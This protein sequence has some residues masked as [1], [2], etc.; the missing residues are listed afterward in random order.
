M[1]TKDKVLTCLQGQRGEYISGEAIAAQLGVGRNSVWKSIKALQDEGYPIQAASKRGYCLPHASDVLSQE[2]L[3]AH[4]GNGRIQVEFHKSVGSTNLRAKELAAQ[5]AP[6]G[7]LVVANQQTA[8]RGRRG[9]SFY[10]PPDTGVYF[11]FVLRPSFALEDVTLITSYA[12]VCT[13]RAI[14]EV[15]GLS[16]QIKW[17]NDIFVDRRKCCGILTEA[18]IMPETGSIDYVVLG[19][20]IN[21]YEPK[22]GFSE[23]S[24]QIAR[25]L[26]QKSEPLPDARARVVALTAEHFM[27]GYERIPLKEHLAQYRDRSLLDGKRVLI[28]QGNQSFHATVLGIDDDFKLRVRLDDGS[29]RA[30]EHGEA[31][32]PSSQLA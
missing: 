1:S 26:W 31:S 18:S 29:E 11:S 6:E 8:G 15:F 10:S 3:Q 21:V 4:I 13:A 25:A 28:T 19:I 16:A 20:G 17:V 12:A 24:A 5:G 23:E 7:T 32:I 14:E 27:A 2:A 9:R 22:G 30:L